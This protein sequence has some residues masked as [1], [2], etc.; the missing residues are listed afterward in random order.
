[1]KKDLTVYPRDT[2]NELTDGRH[3]V[4]LQLMGK[5]FR[6]KSETVFNVKIHSWVRPE[7]QLH[8]LLLGS[9]IQANYLQ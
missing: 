4:G 6:K 7:G 2:C 5:T 8:G 9:G 1:M 3:N